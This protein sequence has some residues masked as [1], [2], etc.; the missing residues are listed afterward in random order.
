[1][2][3]VC[4]FKTCV[5]ERHVSWNLALVLCERLKIPSLT[6]SRLVFPN[7]WCKWKD[8]RRNL[9]FLPFPAGCKQSF[10][11]EARQWVWMSK[12]LFSQ[13]SCAVYVPGALC[14]SGWVPCCHGTAGVCG[15]R[16]GAPVCCP[17]FSIWP[18]LSFS[19]QCLP[20]WQ[21]YK[22][23]YTE[24]VLSR[25]PFSLYGIF[26]WFFP[27]LVVAVFLFSGFWFLPEFSY[28]YM[29]L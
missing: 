23:C 21:I 20:V 4:V 29:L 22:L 11:H 25:L 12:M 19:L 5:V 18:G 9:L 15:H 3:C 28:Q 2:L 17:H 10:L 24:L 27:K 8:R 6:G 7:K 16:P 13:D 26:S 14:C 1:M